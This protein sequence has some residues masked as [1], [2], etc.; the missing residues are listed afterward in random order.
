MTDIYKEYNN[1]MQVPLRLTTETDPV[2][3]MLDQDI[4]EILD[5]I[6][7]HPNRKLIYQL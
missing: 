5:K 2:T 4:T 3:V 7:T 1:P 6:Q